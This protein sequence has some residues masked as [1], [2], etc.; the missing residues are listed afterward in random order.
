MGGSSSPAPVQQNV[1]NTQIPDYLAPYAS[2][3][4]NATQ[5]Q[6]FQTNPDG[7]PN[8]SS[9]KPYQPYS[10]NPSDYFA[11]FSPMQKQAQSTVANLQNP[12]QY[13]QAMNITCL[14]YTSPSPR[15]S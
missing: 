13:G 2:N 15:D 11:D 8:Y 3:M 10:S 9:F 12:S 1:N 4:L 5:A 6:I 14:L 7:S